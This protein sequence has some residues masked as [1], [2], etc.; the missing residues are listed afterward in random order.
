[1]QRFPLLLLAVAAV[2]FG[3]LPEPATA[4]NASWTDP[5]EPFRIADDLYYVGTSGLGAFLFTSDEGHILIDAPLQEN[6]P[7]VLDNIRNLGFDPADIRI[8]LTSHAHFDHVGGL[9]DM[10]EVTGAELVMSEADAAYV[11]D[12]ADFGLEGITDGYPAAPVARTV[13]HLESVSL[14]DVQL[15]AHLTPGHTPGCTSWGGEVE[16]EGESYTFISVCSLSVLS[17]YTLVGDDATYPGQAA[18]YCASVAHLDAQNP[19]IF[20]GPH[21]EWFG[22]EEKLERLRGGELDAFVEPERYRDYL[23]SARE[24]IDAALEAEGVVGGCSGL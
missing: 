4:Q 15:T 8:Q 19:D 9:S 22:L 5:V 14:G 7:L 11:R 20:L 12:G 23:A 13:G 10:L 6:V 17:Y 21:G 3:G 16:I 18:D 24:S 1:M 2:T